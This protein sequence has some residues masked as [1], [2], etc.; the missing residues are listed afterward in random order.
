MDAAGYQQDTSCALQLLHGCVE[1][2]VGHVGKLVHPTMDQETLESS[3]SSLDHG[4][5]LLLTGDRESVVCV[6]FCPTSVQSAWKYFHFVPDCQ[7]SRLPRRLCP[8]NT[9]LLPPAASH[10]ND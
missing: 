3:H 10:K 8:Q 1:I 6:C 7:E 9:F 2:S 4:P 5:E